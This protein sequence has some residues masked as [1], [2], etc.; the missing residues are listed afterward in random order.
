MGSSAIYPFH[1]NVLWTFLL[2]LLSIQ[3]IR[4]SKKET[5]AMDTASYNLSC[6]FHGLSAWNHIHG[7]LQ[8]SGNTDSIVFFTFSEKRHGFLLWHNLPECTI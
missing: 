8:C 1:Q 4:K 2:G 7:R 5:K 3:I 6:S